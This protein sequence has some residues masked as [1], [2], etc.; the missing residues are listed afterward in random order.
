MN[1]AEIRPRT[2][3][4]SVN[5]AMFRSVRGIRNNVVTPNTA[6]SSSGAA[7]T[8]IPAIVSIAK[9]QQVMCRA[10]RTVAS[11]RNAKRDPYLPKGRLE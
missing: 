4:A 8:M 3:D 9:W 1:K 11:E 5:L 2:V 7:T 6:R 10:K